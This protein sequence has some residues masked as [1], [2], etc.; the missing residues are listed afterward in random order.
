MISLQ[1][2]EDRLKQNNQDIDV[3]KELRN[4]LKNKKQNS[5]KAPGRNYA[6]EE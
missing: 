3:F 2:A 6:I 1:M 4:S 5:E